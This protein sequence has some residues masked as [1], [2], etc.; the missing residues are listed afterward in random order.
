M[1]IM[2]ADFHE[3]LPPGA[4][5]FVYVS[6][7]SRVLS[8]SLFRAPL[9]FLLR[10]ERLV[11]YERKESR[12]VSYVHAPRLAAGAQSRRFTVGSASRAA[13]DRTDRVELVGGH[14]RPCLP[15]GSVLPFT[16]ITGRIGCR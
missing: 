1:V 9:E 8:D 13:G 16:L 5:Q 11:S 15:R 7:L 12:D 4:G 2:T 14:S 3:F 6:F 10:S